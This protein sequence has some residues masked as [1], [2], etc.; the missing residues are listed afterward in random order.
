MENYRLGRIC[1]NV[2]A[3]YCGLNSPRAQV[4]GQGDAGAFFATRWMLEGAAA[5]PATPCAIDKI[6]GE[7]G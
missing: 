1:P 4:R 5:K 3:R 6:A 2:A 7:G